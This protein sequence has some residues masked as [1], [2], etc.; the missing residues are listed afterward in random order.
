MYKKVVLM[1]LPKQDLLRPPGA[2]PILAAAC[3]DFDVDYEILDFNLWLYKNTDIDTWQLINDNWDTVNPLVYCDA[4]FYQVFLQKAQEFVNIVYSY[5]P[6]LVAISVFADNGSACA[7]EIISLLNQSKTFDIAIGGTGIRARM[8]TLD[9]QELCLVLK[10]RRLIDYYLFGEGEIIFR[11]LLNQNTEYPGINNFDLEQIE[12]L[13]AF[14]F[15]SY[16][17]IN[18]LDYKYINKPEI[19]VTGSKGCVRACTYCDVA[20]YW[21]KFRYRTGKSIA[22]ELYHYYKSTGVQNFEFSDSLINGS[23]KQFREMN[24]AII[25]LQTQDPTFKISYKGQF[26]CRDYRQMKEV[27]YANMKLAGCD[28]IYV[29]VE[30]FSDPVRH[31]MAKKFN[32]EDLDYHLRMCGRYGIANSFL[33]LIGYPTETLA[34]HQQNLA[35]L[36][37]YQH[38]S[39]AG[40]IE[41]IV[42]GYTANILEDTPLFYMQEQLQIENEFESN[43]KFDS[44]NWVSLKN[45]TLDLKERIRRWVEL[46][47]LSISLGY[48]LPRNQHYISRFIDVLKRNQNKKRIFQISKG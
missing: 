26:I 42:F 15:P 17:K 6:N 40:V 31:D 47:E 1:S 46:T 32:N 41:M 34:D 37:K 38:Y 12:D 18:P 33:M 14:S 39:Q 23:L 22:N 7:L 30:S 44:G 8:P 25:D 5:Q 43:E 27:D 2:M 13:D 10:E 4:D 24:L 16:K 28:Y 20:K 45:P 36:K 35:T 29:G 21:P 48:R 9:S 19:V 11:K 3:E